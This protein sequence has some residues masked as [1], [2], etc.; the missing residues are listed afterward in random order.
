MSPELKQ[1]LLNMASQH[2]IS[3]RTSVDTRGRE[4]A[5][6]VKDEEVL[7]SVPLST[8]KSLAQKLERPE[9]DQ[10]PAQKLL[11]I[12]V[13]QTGTLNCDDIGCTTCGAFPVRGLL[14]QLDWCAPGAHTA[15]ESATMF[16]APAQN[17]ELISAIGEIDL[18]HAVRVT[19]IERVLKVFGLVLLDHPQLA[20]AIKSA[21]SKL[22]LANS[23]DSE[24]TS[25]FIEGWPCKSYR[26][27]TGAHMHW[28][29]MCRRSYGANSDILES[30]GSVA[31]DQDD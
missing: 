25:R 26:D 4:N 27:L 22:L 16:K 19:S 30:F 14:K 8:A 13:N 6:L 15:G 29:S 12:I 5:E 3:I 9:A 2:G 21:I 24:Y 31:E 23:K 18:T 20:T 28:N 7:L 1:R 17:D 10:S 11:S